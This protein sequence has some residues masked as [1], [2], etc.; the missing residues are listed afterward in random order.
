MIDSCSGCKYL[1]D[2]GTCGGFE[3]YGLECPPLPCEID[4]NDCFSGDQVQKDE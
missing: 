2:D 4:K 3:C 1:M